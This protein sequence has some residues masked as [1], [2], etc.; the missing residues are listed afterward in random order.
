PIYADR[1]GLSR[2]EVKEMMEAETWMSAEEAVEKGFAD[3]VGTKKTEE[4]TNSFSGVL[5]LSMSATKKSAEKALKAK[6][7]KEEQDVS[8]PTPASTDPT[9]DEDV[10]TPT[11]PEKEE[12][13]EEPTNKV[14]KETTM[15]EEE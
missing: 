14:N 15:T 9:G 11:D 3:Q 13:K 6:A 7:D 10:E 4:A 8:T 5:A 1:S 12:V 2:E